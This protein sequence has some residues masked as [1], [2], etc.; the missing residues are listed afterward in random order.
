MTALTD[1]RKRKSAAIV[2][3]N[4]IPWKG[5]FDLIHAVDEF[6]LFDDVQYT[7][8]DWRNRNRI[9]GPNGPVWLSI[10]VEN[11]GKYFQRIRETAVS[12]TRWAEQHWKTIRH[13]YARAPWFG[14]YSQI[15]EELYLGCRETLLSRINYR[16]ICAICSLLGIHTR[17]SWSMDYRLAEGKTGRL[18]AICLE[19]GATD[20]VSGP[21][22]RAYIE[23]DLFSNNGL[24]LS[25]FDYSGYPEY[26]QLHRPFLHEVSILDLIFNEGP[27]SPKYMKTFD[28]PLC[29]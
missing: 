14:H 5:Y 28:A 19:L 23:S 22:A 26:R 18:A 10:P 27:D 11:K 2:Q 16:F 24:R 25:F 21:A 8:R 29:R 20:Y 4:Y 3:S 1:T 9:Q 15:F 12:D 7:R 13:C 17:I 6:V